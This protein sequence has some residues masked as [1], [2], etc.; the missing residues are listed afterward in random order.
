VKPPSVPWGRPTRPIRS[1][2][3]DD[4]DQDPLALFRAIGPHDGA[5]SVRRAA[6]APDHLPAVVLGNEQLEDDGV[7]VLLELVNL[8]LGRLVDEGPCQELEQLLQALI[9]LAFISFLTVPLG[10]APCSIQPR[11]FCSSSTI[12]DGSV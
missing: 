3:V 12:V 10:C 4:L 2:S 6:V 1:R 11:S 9:P 8:D 7:L 5:Q